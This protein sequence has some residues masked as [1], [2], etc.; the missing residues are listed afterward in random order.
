MKKPEELRLNNL[1]HAKSPEREKWQI[2]PIS[3][4]DLHYLLFPN[5]SDSIPVDIKPIKLSEEILL[6]CG[7][8]K[9]ET[10][11]DWSVFNRSDFCNCLLVNGEGLRIP[12]LSITINYLHTFQNLIHALTNQE[13]NI[14]L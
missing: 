14:K 2:H 10:K 13:L 5:A 12:Y 1:V 3:I 11:Q 9:T 8:V 7:F 4:W 6:K